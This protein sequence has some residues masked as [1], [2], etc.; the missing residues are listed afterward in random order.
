[1]VKHGRIKTKKFNQPDRWISSR[2]DYRINYDEEEIRKAKSEKDH[3]D[4]QKIRKRHGAG[5]NNGNLD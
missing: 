4:V 2:R 1:M 5:A 3:D